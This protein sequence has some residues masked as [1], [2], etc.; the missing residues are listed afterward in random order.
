MGTA[1]KYM[2]AYDSFKRAE[3][4]CPEQLSDIENIGVHK[5]SYMNKLSDE[6]FTD[7][8][9][10]KAATK[11][12]VD[13]FRQLTNKVKEKGEY[14]EDLLNE[15][16]QK[17]DKIKTKEAETIQLQQEKEQKDQEIAE[18]KAKLQK[19]E[20]EKVQP[21]GNSEPEVV[22][23][24]VEV[25]KVVEKEV[26]PDE[27]QEELED[28]RLQKKM[29][30]KDNEDKASFIEE[31]N[32]KI[33]EQRQKISS[34][35]INDTVPDDKLPEMQLASLLKFIDTFLRD[36]SGYTLLKGKYDD[37]SVKSKNILMQ[38]ISRVEDW[39]LLMKQAVNNDH[40]NVGN[41]IIIENMED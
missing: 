19:M 23:K 39:C 17:D 9:K 13:Q 25:E 20:E 22:E 3:L 31:Q 14:S 32:G 2:Q 21:V 18:L 34:L 35:Q 11:I 36:T 29:L 10:S 15:I 24:I 41:N 4:Y 7:I 38:S 1:R 27:I 26:I 40:Y 30:E 12:N 6:Q 33:L 5:L 37:I 8:M 16:R 28:L